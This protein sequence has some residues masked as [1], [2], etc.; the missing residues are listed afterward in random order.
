MQKRLIECNYSHS[1]A[2][3]YGQYFV[4]GRVGA[5]QGP[6]TR[7]PHDPVDEH[8]AVWLGR[9]HLRLPV[10]R[11]VQ[12]RRPVALRR[13]RLPDV[14]LLLLHLI[15]GEA[16]FHI[17]RNCL[18]ISPVFFLTPCCWL[19]LQTSANTLVVVSIFRFVAVCKPEISESEFYDFLLCV[20]ST[21][22]KPLTFRCRVPCSV[23]WWASKWKCESI[24]QLDCNS[25]IQEREARGNR[26]ML[27]SPLLTRG[28][29]STM[30]V[31]TMMMGLLL[32]I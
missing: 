14:R 9:L 3:H 12:F 17:G 5:M 32:L 11:G 7:R 28:H 24:N 8:G 13:R 15:S 19:S 23:L 31:E 6:V 10:H 4:P 16:S 22:T 2:V 1:L 20:P 21:A 26:K 25:P 27:Y 29:R 30:G 18:E